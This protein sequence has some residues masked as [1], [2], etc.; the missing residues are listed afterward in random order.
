MPEDAVRY[1]MR[2]SRAIAVTFMNHQVLGWDDMKQIGFEGILRRW[3]AQPHLRT[4]GYAWM[5][6]VARWAMLD[7]IRSDRGTS[8][9]TK[10]TH[11][12][13]NQHHTYLDE[14]WEGAGVHDTYD[15]GT[16]AWVCEKL[17]PRQRQCVRLIVGGLTS[18]EAAN[19]LGI[20]VQAV[21]IH[22]SYARDRLIA[23]GI[24]PYDIIPLR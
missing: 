12:Q 11:G 17:T 3:H 14:E 19:A 24:S 1:A 7:A 4:G 22:L 5:G 23:Q 15:D 6:K 16:V 8:G 18:T 2:A 13:P 20:S 10:N 9:G 21:T